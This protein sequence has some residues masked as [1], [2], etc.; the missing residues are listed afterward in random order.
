VPSKQ[1]IQKIIDNITPFQEYIMR[2]A[3]RM[4][5]QT[6]DQLESSMP[7]GKQLEKLKQLI[8]DILY[9]YRDS[10]LRATVELDIQQKTK[11]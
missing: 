3:S 7:E 9:E 11:K 2:G 1:E 10:L 4:V 5:G 6:L 8:E